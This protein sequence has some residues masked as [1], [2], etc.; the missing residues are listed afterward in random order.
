MMERTLQGKVAIVSGS[1]SGIGAAIAKE[2]ASRGASVVINYPFARLRD[3]AEQ[4][5]GAITTDAIA[6]EA[7]LSTVHGPRALVEAAVKRFGHVDILINNAAVAVNKPFEEQTMDDWDSLVNLNG[8]GTFLLTQA[9]LPHLAQEGGR[10]VNIVS[11]SAREAPALQ[12]IYAG[13]KGMCDSFTKVWAKELPPK[14][15]VTVNAVSPGP[16][17]TEGF[18][19]AGDAFMEK[20]QPV[21]NRTPV[22]GRMGEPEEIAFAVAFLCEPR[23]R[24]INGAHLMVNGGLFID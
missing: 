8:R 16:T 4:T 19:Q 21:I 11:I 6:V 23:A 12:T 1:C 20:M 3:Q 2:L 5:L 13:T 18:A 7:D 24:W 15:G 14:Y 17:L 9:V 10:I 22:A